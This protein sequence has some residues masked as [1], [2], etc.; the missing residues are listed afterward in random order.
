MTTESKVAIETEDQKQHILRYEK[1]NL[2]EKPADIGYACIVGDKSIRIFPKNKIEIWDLEY[3]R[4][5]EEDADA[6]GFQALSYLER[7]SWETDYPEWLSLDNVKASIDFAFMSSGLPS[8]FFRTNLFLMNL[9]TFEDH[10]AAS[11]KAFEKLY[12]GAEPVLTDMNFTLMRLGQDQFY[13][14]RLES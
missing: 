12:P 6:F 9:E 8:I 7:L 13:S 14:N 11:V 10:R 5:G 1:M 2:V 3:Q 4:E